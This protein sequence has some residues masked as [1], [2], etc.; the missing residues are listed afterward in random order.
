MPAGASLWAK[1][2]AVF[3]AASSLQI[4][5]YA[6]PLWGG[7]PAWMRLPDQLYTPAVLVFFFGPSMAAAAVALRLLYRHHAAQDQVLPMTGVLV[8][9][10]LTVVSGYLGVLVSFNTWGT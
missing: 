3:A 5:M 8:I 1:V 10:V 4:L 7:A 9:V 6:R 2:A